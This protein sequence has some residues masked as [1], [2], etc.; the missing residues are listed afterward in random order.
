MLLVYGVM[1]AVVIG[2]MLGGKL[3]NVWYCGA[4][5]ESL[6]LIISIF[7]SRS[8][9]RMLDERQTALGK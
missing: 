3:G 7:L 4:I 1:A 5:A 8:V 2:Y 6:S 9:Y